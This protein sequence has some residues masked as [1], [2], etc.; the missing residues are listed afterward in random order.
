[1]TPNGGAAFQV[2]SVAPGPAVRNAVAAW[3]V[4]ATI[5]RTVPPA[6]LPGGCSPLAT[7]ATAR[8]ISEVTF[9]QCARNTMRA[10][11]A[12]MYTEL[13]RGPTDVIVSA[14]TSGRR[15]SG[16]SDDCRLA[17]AS[18]VRRL[19][20]ELVVERRTPRAQHEDR[21]ETGEQRRRFQRRSPRLR[22]RLE[23]GPR[24]WP[25]ERTPDSRHRF[26][27]HEME[28]RRACPNFGVPFVVSVTINNEYR[29]RTSQ[30]EVH[31]P[32]RKQPH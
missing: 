22:R 28:S 7:A 1:M 3:P 23:T 32:P 16:G 10:S 17:L 9:D 21:D 27:V 20:P 25:A 30:H 8:S 15:R 2:S 6:S 5:A 12:M 4:I 31:A 18:S 19:D 24:V 14:P 29:Q 11:G 26:K 13:G